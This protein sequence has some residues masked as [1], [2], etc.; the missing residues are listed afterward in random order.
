MG[1]L[2]ALAVTVVALPWVLWLATAAIAPAGWD[3]ARHLLDRQ[4]TGAL[5]L[6]AVCVIG[7]LAWGSFVLSLLVEIPAQLRGVRAPRLPGLQ[8]SQRAAA[9]LVGSLL[10]LLPTGTALA[11]SSPAEASPQTSVPASAAA[12]PGQTTHASP[13]ATAAAA[14]SEARDTY[15]VRDTRPAESLWSIAEHLYGHGEDY[16]HIAEANEGQTMVDGSVFRTDA[17]IQPGWVLQLPADVPR[18]DTISA[19]DAEHRAPDGEHNRASDTDQEGSVRAHADAH[20]DKK[21]VVASGDTISEIAREETGDAGN[22]PEVFEA[23]RGEQPAGLPSIDDPDRIVPGQRVTIP[24]ALHPGTPAP[25]AP[26]NRRSKRS[27]RRGPAPARTRPDPPT[28]ARTNPTPTAARSRL[29]L[30]AGRT[31]LRTAHRTSARGAMTVRPGPATAMPALASR[32]SPPSPATTAERTRRRVRPQS[33]LD[34]RLLL[35]P[36]APANRLLT[37]PT[38]RSPR[39]KTLRSVLRLGCRLSGC[40]LRS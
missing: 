14:E 29:R 38:K 28:V 4:D 40:S 10:V 3:A 17:P 22:W 2:V 32:R 24:A 1:A 7:W 9:V 13:K 36:S 5:A 21:R 16:T 12:V 18:I 6:L 33:L 30:A 15:T 23:S 20:E 25:N 31:V 39:P 26:Q 11:A 35:R 34:R 37:T 8:V 19:P 27:R